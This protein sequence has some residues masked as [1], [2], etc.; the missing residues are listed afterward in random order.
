MR[1]CTVCMSLLEEGEDVLCPL[2]EAFERYWRE[3]LHSQRKEQD[4]HGWLED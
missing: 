3:L 2:C 1:F 4:I